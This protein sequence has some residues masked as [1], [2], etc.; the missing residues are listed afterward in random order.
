MGEVSK[1]K[2]LNNPITNE[3]GYNTSNYCT[4]KK[5]IVFSSPAVMSLNQTLPGWE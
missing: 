2:S 5:V 4:A 1:E 3:I